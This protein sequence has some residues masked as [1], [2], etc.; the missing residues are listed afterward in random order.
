MLKMRDVLSRW[1]ARSLN[2][3]EAAEVLGVSD[4]TFRRYVDRFEA[5]GDAGLVDRRLG[6][7]SG[8]A[9]PS[10]TVSIITDLNNALDGKTPA[11]YLHALSSAISPSQTS[12]S[13]MP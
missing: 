5:D 13:H 8:R 9:V 10:L 3:L 11:E 12:P 6:R 4:R 1:E 7:R 2:Q